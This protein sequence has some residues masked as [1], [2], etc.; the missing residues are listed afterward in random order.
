M[1]TK[2]GLANALHS[3]DPAYNAL[4]GYFEGKCG[5]VLR[6]LLANAARAGVAR[7]DVD[8]IE[9][10]GS[11]ANLCIYSPIT[12]DETRPGRMVD[13]FVDGLLTPSKA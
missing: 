1:A 4:P 9:V 3:G 7:T 2:H 6:D 13:V 11:V 10:L 12:K 8:A 5:P